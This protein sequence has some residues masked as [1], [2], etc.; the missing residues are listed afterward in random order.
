M[1]IDLARSRR[2]STMMVANL[3]RFTFR[4]ASIYQFAGVSDELN[5]NLSWLLRICLHSV[6]GI[7][8]K[9]F[10]PVMKGCRSVVLES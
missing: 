8:F 6:F 2:N 7:L 1:W 4:S 10:E 5:G 3:V 9:K